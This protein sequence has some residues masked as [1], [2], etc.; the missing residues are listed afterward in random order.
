[1]CIFHISF[2]QTPPTL[3]HTNTQTHTRQK[4]KCLHK[5]LF[6]LCW[7]LLISQNLNFGIP[8]GQP[9]DEFLFYF[10]FLGDFIQFQKNIICILMPSPLISFM[11]TSLQSQPVT[12]NCLLNTCSWISKKYLNIDLSKLNICYVHPNPLLHLSV[13]PSFIC[14]GWKP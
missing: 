4:R 9:Q 12:H 8:R 13:M 14:S 10:H 11:H 7:F 5:T 3:L 1:M 2:L 6:S